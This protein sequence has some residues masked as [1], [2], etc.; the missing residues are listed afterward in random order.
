MNPA[1][2]EKRA[3][4][5]VIS[6]CYNE[7]GNIEHA[8]ERVQKVFANLDYDYELIFVDNASTDGSHE[9]FKNLV[10]K[11]PHV[12]VLFL[13]RNFGTSQSSYLA[14][15]RACS[16]AAAVLLDCD[17]QDPPEVI[18]AFIKAWENGAEVVYGVY[19]KRKE[20]WF[21]KLG[22]SLFYRVFSWLSY[23]N[24]PLHSGDFSLIGRRALNEMI[25]LPEK[26]IFIR[27]LRLWVGFK[28]VGV[29]YERDE[30]F[31]GYTKISFLRYFYWAKKAIVNF[32]YKPLEYI[33]CLAVGSA[34]LTTVFAAFHLYA[35]F[36]HGAPRGF[37]TLLLVVMTIGTVQLLCLS[38][39]AEY[40]IRIFD[41]VK[42][43]PSYIVDRILAQKESQKIVHVDKPQERQL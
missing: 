28:Q 18:P 17:L 43:R 6:A 27:G 22:Y 13:S 8:Q 19:S 30:R 1:K 29:E 25:A 37:M 11:D 3:V 20:V 39:I 34:V 35:Y 12:K 16:G 40:L 32:S 4:I 41:E 10:E 9:I 5:S 23:L 31:S 7:E 33:S 15:L 26:D 14:G 38:V 24:I 21:R 42:G 2:R 36:M